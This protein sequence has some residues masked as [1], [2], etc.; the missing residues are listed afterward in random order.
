MNYVQAALAATPPFD[1]QLLLDLSKGPLKQYIQAIPDDSIAI[2]HEALWQGLILSSRGQNTTEQYVTAT[3]N[4]VSVFLLSSTSSSCK[5]VRLF[6]FS[7]KTWFEAYDAAEKA[8]DHG[9]TK[10]ALQVL[11]CLG[12]LLK[13]NPDTET[14][15]AILRQ[16]CRR[17]VATLL[18]VNSHRQVKTACIALTCFA[19]KTDLLHHFEYI[20]EEGLTEVSPSQ[21]RCQ[22]HQNSTGRNYPSASSGATNF[23]MALLC[24]IESLE[25]RSAS[26]KLFSLLLHADKWTRNNTTST[27][28]ATAI[29]AFL[30][31][32]SDTL[33]DFAANVL[34]VIIDDKAR[35]LAFCDLYKPTATS[36]ESSLVLYLSVLRTGRI[37]KYVSQSGMF[38]ILVCGMILTARAPQTFRKYSIKLCEMCLAR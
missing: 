8:F 17:L 2:E 14:A 30:E 9:K 33:Q 38:S 11:E 5:L 15:L 13:S 10:P 34:P 18:S 1:H 32:R 6:A 12:G 21:R 29:D 26:L 28:A 7:Q 22:L 37:A 27:L 20:V 35:F 4:C 24:A 31:D 16:S 36:S 25:T 23:L 3:C 19:K